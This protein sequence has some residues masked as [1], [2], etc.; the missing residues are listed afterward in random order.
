MP[1]YLLEL[2]VQ[3]NFECIIPHC[4]EIDSVAP[5]CCSIVVVLESELRLRAVAVLIEI[6]IE[7]FMTNSK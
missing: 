5:R 6:L 3:V 4:K 1:L 7:V 2:L